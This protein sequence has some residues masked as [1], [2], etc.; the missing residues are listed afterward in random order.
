MNCSP[1]HAYLR[2]TAHAP[3]RRPPEARATIERSHKTIKSDVIR[4]DQPA[5]LDEARARRSL[6]RAHNTVRLHSAIGDTTPLTSW[7]LEVQPAE[8]AREA[9][10]VRRATSPSSAA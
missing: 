9:R 3:A 7:L 10:H 4:P 8:A 2:A 5:T 6:G 1:A